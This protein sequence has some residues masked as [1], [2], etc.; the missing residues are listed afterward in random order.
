MTLRPHYAVTYDNCQF[1]CSLTE[2]GSPF[3]EEL[4]AVDIIHFEPG[5]A[6][7][8]MK[9]NN[10]DLIG[11][12]IVFGLECA[13]ESESFSNTFSV[14]FKAQQ[15]C[16]ANLRAPK[17]NDIKRLWGQALQTMVLPRFDYTV[18]EECSG[19]GTYLVYEL[20]VRPVLGG[21][22]T[23][24]EIQFDPDYRTIDVC[25]CNEECPSNDWDSEMCRGIP[26][27]TQ[28]EARQVA[29]LYSQEG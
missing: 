7:I 12:T 14:E 8:E 16:D 25:K 28:Y 24:P 20:D 2:N 23:A 9:T 26:T 10:E 4:S 1:T 27:V 15:R 3:S 11:R 19:E 18:D 22:T 13:V 21:D 6:Q 5:M 17:V 29:K